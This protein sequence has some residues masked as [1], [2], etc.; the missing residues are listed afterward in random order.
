MNP[1]CSQVLELHQLDEVQPG[2]IAIIRTAIGSDITPQLIT[3]TVRAI[4]P[5][6]PSSDWHLIEYTTPTTEGVYRFPVGPTSI[7][8]FIRAFRTSEDQA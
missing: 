5:W 6:S 2:D 7:Y 8:T 4:T 1:H 3:G